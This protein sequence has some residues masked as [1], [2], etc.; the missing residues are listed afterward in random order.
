MRAVTRGAGV[1]VVLGVTIIAAA[2]FATLPVTVPRCGYAHSKNW[3][4]AAVYPW[5]MSCRAAR[6][7]LAKS[8]ARH[9]PTINFT[10][11]G[12]YT[13]DG[14]AVKIAG[15]WWVC[16]GRMGYYFCGYPYRP[17]TAPGVGGGTT[18]RGR[19]TK[20]FMYQACE[21]GVYLC[22]RRAQIYQPPRSYH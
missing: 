10:A 2:A 22:K 6:D 9:A 8:E 17:A 18:Y 20:E 5:H 19:F 11:D 12:A 15:K 7:T 13:F 14:A 4:R 16:G 21:D 1:A 3:G